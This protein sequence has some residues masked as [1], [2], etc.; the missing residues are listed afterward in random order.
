MELKQFFLD[1]FRWR[2]RFNNWLCKLE[3]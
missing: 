1:I 2:K 3:R